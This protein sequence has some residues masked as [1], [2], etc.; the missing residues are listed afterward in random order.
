MKKLIG[1]TGKTGA[2]KTTICKYLKEKGAYII[3]GDIVARQVLIDDET[4]LQELNVSFDGVLNEDG[5]LNRRLLA[6]KAFS[7]EENT[8]KLNSIIHP[9]INSAIEKEAETAFENFDVVVVDAAAIIE[10]G[11]AD[12]CHVLL[13]ANAPFDVRKERIMKRDNLSEEDAL[14]RMNGQ[15]KDDFYLSRADFVIKSYEPYDVETQM[16]SIEKELFS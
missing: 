3:D 7:S 13:V 16:K 12:K 4:L 5:S 11:F 8:R 9:A 1:L 15:K 10:S 6:S 14:V 2:G